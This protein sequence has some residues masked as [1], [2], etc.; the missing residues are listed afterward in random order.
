M[1][2]EEIRK[3]LE[4]DILMYAVGTPSTM[5]FSVTHFL[6]QSLN[7]WRMAV[8]VFFRSGL[9]ICPYAYCLFW[10]NGYCGAANA[11]VDTTSDTK[12]RIFIFPPF[13]C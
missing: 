11:I 9:K 2:L 3:I 4:S 13:L 8:S 12:A 10:G 1:S 6:R 5:T 7:F